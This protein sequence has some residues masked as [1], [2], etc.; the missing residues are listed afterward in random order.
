MCGASSAA[1]ELLPAKTNQ[2]PWLDDLKV[3]IETFLQHF[4]QVNLQ[5]D[6][7]KEAGPVYEFDGS[8]GVVVPEELLDHDLGSQF[9][10]A[11]WMRHAEAP[12]WAR[13]GGG[14]ASC[15]D[16][17]GHISDCDGEGGEVIR[18]RYAIW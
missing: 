14:Q 13:G 8:R 10:I 4:G 1:V 11:T 18:Q 5:V 3:M 7:G 12:R 15:R 16:V 6:E 17:D 2:T 9:T